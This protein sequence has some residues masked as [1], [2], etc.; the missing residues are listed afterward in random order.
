MKIGIITGG[1]TGEREVS[2]RS[3]K[4]IKSAIDFSEVETFIFPEE[5]ENFLKVRESFKVVIPVIHGVGAED[6][7]VQGFLEI[8]G[9]PYIFSSIQAHSIGID[10]R[11]TKEIVSKLGILVAKEINSFP[12]F[13]KPNFGGSSVASQLCHNKEELEKLMLENPGVEFI[14]EE[15]IKGREVT[16]GIIEKGGKKIV[17]PVIE[18][19][20]KGGFFDFDSKYNP[21]M[22]AEEVCPAKVDTFIYKEL[23][24]Q[25]L[26]AYEAI[27]ASHISRVDFFLTADNKIYFLEINTIPGMTDTSLVPKML[28]EEGIELGELLK[29]WVSTFNIN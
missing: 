18:V 16:V 12:L 28:R 7:S 6:G 14:L 2:I 10:K 24:R 9:I 29:E 21:D 8:L 19:I 3:A 13:A 23:Q 11:K 4:N 25:A 5:I 26:V 22:L 17:L 15:P 20:P 27:G 1:T